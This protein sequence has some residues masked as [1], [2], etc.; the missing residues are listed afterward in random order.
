MPLTGDIVYGTGID[1]NGI[2][3]T[4]D[5]KALLIVQ[6][7]TGLLFRVDPATGSPGPSTS[8]RDQR[9]RAAAGRRRLYAVQ[10]RLNTVA[11]IRLGRTG[12]TGRVVERLT[13]PGFD[14]PTTVVA[15][16]NRFH[17]RNAPFTTPPTPET[18]YTAVAV[19]R[20]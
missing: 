15:Y 3:R 17:L 5:R 18:P 2:A 10:N 7:G 4:P 9:R 11:V 16:G 20:P 6:S 19:P 14:V 13:D 1:A 12:R 8:E